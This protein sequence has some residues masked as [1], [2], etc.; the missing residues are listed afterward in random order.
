MAQRDEIVYEVDLE[1]DAD[2]V[3]RYLAWLKPHVETVM[4]YPGFT[5]ATIRTVEGEGANGRKLFCVQYVLSNRQSLQEYF[6]T[7]AERMR[8]DGNSRWGGKFSATRRVMQVTSAFRVS[9][10]FSL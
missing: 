8:S 7:H 5:S 2:I 10:S 9:A 3:D 1:V 6:D 4:S